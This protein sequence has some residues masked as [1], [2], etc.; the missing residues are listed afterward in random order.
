MENAD[1]NPDN[2]FKKLKHTFII[3]GRQY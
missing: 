3:F 2:N 1:N